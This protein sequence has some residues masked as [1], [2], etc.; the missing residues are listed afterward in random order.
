MRAPRAGDIITT[1][2]TVIVKRVIPLSRALHLGD[3]CSCN[4]SCRSYNFSSILDTRIS[5]AEPLLVVAIQMHLW[6]AADD[7]CCIITFSEAGLL[8]HNHVYWQWYTLLHDS[9]TPSQ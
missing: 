4:L 2:D 1:V 7:M 9:L 3:I 8:H 5:H 6:D